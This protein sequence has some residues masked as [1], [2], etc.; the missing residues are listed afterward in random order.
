M[1]LLNYVESTLNNKPIN[2]Y[3][4]KHKYEQVVTK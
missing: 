1:L 3:I 4:E 2:I